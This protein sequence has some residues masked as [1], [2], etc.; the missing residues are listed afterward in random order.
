MRYVLATAVAMLLFA[1][2]AVLSEELPAD[3]VL[4]DRGTWLAARD[5]QRAVSARERDGFMPTDVECRHDPAESEAFVKPQV[6][7][8]WIPNPLDLDW[9]FKI[10]GQSTATDLM[11]RAYETQG[12]RLVSRSTFRTGATEQEWL[13]EVWH[14]APD[15]D[16]RG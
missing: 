7:L 4:S 5:A 12:F 13:C 1:V 9:R 6:R 3:D 2:T 10:A 16:D 15:G 11:R 8:A 14:K